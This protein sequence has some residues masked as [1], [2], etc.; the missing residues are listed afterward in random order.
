MKVYSIP[1]PI[2]IFVCLSNVLLAE[3]SDDANKY[4][5][6][7]YNLYR[8]GKIDQSMELL[9]KTLE[10]DPDH[11]EAY[12]GLGSIYFRQNMYEDAAR[13]FNRVIRIKPEYT[14]A[15]ERLWLIYKKMGLNDKADEAL[16][17][18]KETLIKR[19]QALS[20]QSPQEIKPSASSP[21][22][23]K[24]GSK[25][26]AAK[27]DT[28]QPSEIKSSGTTASTTRLT[29]SAPSES[30]EEESKEYVGEK[31]D[32]LSVVKPV[33]SKI[34]ESTSR[35]DNEQRNSILGTGPPRTKSVDT[36][37]QSSEIES[38]PNPS[39]EYKSQ[40]TQTEQNN[41]FKSFK[42]KISRVFCEFAELL[43]KPYIGKF[44]KGF[45][46]YIITIQIWLCAAASLFIY[47]RKTNDKKYL[48][49]SNVTTKR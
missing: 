12:F 29:K 16:Q 47:L 21:Q 10:I 7:A 9:K 44:L 32:M 35:S 43:N 39:R 48:K 3:S 22:E 36:T 2:L 14:Q 17:K 37:I 24:E 28:S 38:N 6:A 49:K 27:V 30:E 45:I 20:V 31:K 41:Q 5:L 11:V 42:N 34:K 40:Q 26:P 15:Y 46:C 33:K 13:E 18:F 1:F 4:Y 23:E 8:Y 19:A 25:L